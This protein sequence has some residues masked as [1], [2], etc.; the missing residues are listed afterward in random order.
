M[1]TGTTKADRR[2][3][4]E[5]IM[6][7]KRRLSAACAKAA[8]RMSAALERGYG[9]TRVGSTGDLSRGSYYMEDDHVFVHIAYTLD[10]AP[11]V[12]GVM[13]RVSGRSRTNVYST[14]QL[15]VGMLSEERRM[16]RGFGRGVWRRN[17][18]T[19][20]V[21]VSLRTAYGSDDSAILL[22]L[23]FVWNN[24]LGRWYKGTDEKVTRDV[25]AA[26]VERIFNLKKVADT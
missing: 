24:L 8:D 17:R 20:G 7:R 12:R 18:S 6:R 22:S 15:P 21:E 26:A 5:R 13:D 9:M 11:L 1:S 19:G 25:A 10:D 3:R 23:G 2:R 4:Y 14:L 16:G